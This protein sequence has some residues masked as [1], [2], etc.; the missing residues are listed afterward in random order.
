M[1]APDVQQLSSPE[2]FRKNL[3]SLSLQDLMKLIHEQ[4]IRI[5]E[6]SASNKSPMEANH[7]GLYN[8]SIVQKEDPSTIMQ[9]TRQTRGK[10][11]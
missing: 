2:E 6:D 3:R 11:D 1:K 8:Q 5:R 4:N 7:Y 10:L 9:K